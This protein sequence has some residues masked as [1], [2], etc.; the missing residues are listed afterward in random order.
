ME[1]KGR[2]GRKE[3]RKEK[4]GEEIKLKEIENIVHVHSNTHIPD[5][6]VEK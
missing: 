3:G 1:G 2:K 5:K 6:L 4:R